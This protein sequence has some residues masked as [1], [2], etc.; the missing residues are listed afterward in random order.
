MKFKVEVAKFLFFY[1]QLHICMKKISFKPD[2]LCNFIK[3]KMWP[4]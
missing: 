2:N 3:I 1:A 4:I